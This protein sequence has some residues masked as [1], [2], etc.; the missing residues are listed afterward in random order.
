MCPNLSASFGWLICLHSSL[1]ISR[2][3]NQSGPLIHGELAKADMHT[4]T[5]QAFVKLTRVV[6][7]ISF[8][9]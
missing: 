4:R 5:N 3:H 1:F 9:L 7:L 8:C 6:D 2:P